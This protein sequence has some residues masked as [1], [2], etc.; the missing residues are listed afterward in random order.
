MEI[1]NPPA[2][3]PDGRT[4][5]SDIGSLRREIHQSVPFP[6]VAV[7][8]TLTIQRAAD[9]LNAAFAALLKPYD[10]TVTQYN[11]LRIV[12]GAGETGL[13]T[14]EVGERLI[15]RDPDVPRLLERLAA[16][17]LVRRARSAEDRRITSCLLTPE[18]RR[19]LD[20]LEAPI[21]ALHD[22]H[23]AGLSEAEQV[24]LVRLLD[25]VRG[26]VGGGQVGR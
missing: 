23:F 17:G 7:E 13:S 24:T 14:H 19:L 5:G 2:P 15:K 22:H 11:A 20:A 12:R 3:T 6:S 18:G 4:V 16:A 1:V 26:A 21:R 9:D 8:A 10:L 25:R